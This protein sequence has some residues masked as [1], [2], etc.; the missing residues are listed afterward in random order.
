MTDLA[1]RTHTCPPWCVA[2]HDVNQDVHQSQEVWLTSANGHDVAVHAY[3]DSTL[4]RHTIMVGESE[5]DQDAT[6][7]LMSAIRQ[8]MDLPLR[9]AVR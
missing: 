2:R 9:A 7:E 6:V 5:F 3:Y 4:D 8:A 1:V